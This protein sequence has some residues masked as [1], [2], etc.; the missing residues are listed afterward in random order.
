MSHNPA[1]EATCAKS[2]AGAS[3]PRYTNSMNL[4]QQLIFLCKQ[5]FYFEEAVKRVG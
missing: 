1:F 3:T 4:N 2:R 5:L